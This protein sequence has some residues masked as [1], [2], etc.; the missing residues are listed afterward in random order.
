M[1]RKG[2]RGSV[3]E[4]FGVEVEEEKARRLVYTRDEVSSRN[5]ILI[6][7]R[8]LLL[9]AFAIGSSCCVARARLPVLEAG[10]SGGV[11]L[12]FV[13]NFGRGHADPWFCRFAGRRKTERNQ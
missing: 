11:W 5:G 4:W 1:T 12:I 3:G 7:G 9:F 2:K 8:V 6:E 13:R 10:S